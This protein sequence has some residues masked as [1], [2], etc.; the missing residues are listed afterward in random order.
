MLRSLKELESY[1]VSAINGEVGKVTDFL[2]D[3]QH[4]TARYLVTDT[5]GFWEVSN[6]VLISPISF[7]SVDWSTRLFQV[8]L[9]QE[10]VKKSPSVDLAK[11]V[12]RQYEREYSHYY[13]WPYYWGFAGS[14]AWG[15]GP[16]PLAL[17]DRSTKG[18][19]AR[20]QETN[21]DPHLRS[22]N[23]VIGY[24]VHGTDGEIGHIA[25]FIMDDETWTIRY[26]VIDTS[27]WWIGKKVLVAPHWAN[28]ISWSE[29]MVYMALTREAIKSSPEW[30]QTALVEREFEERLYSHYS[31][32]PYW[33][34][35]ELEDKAG[36][37]PEA[38][39]HLAL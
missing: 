34:R 19:T 23:A 25:D 28:K 8:A 39:R 3:D 33:L 18:E 1:K 32:P 17:A 35:R 14:W 16:Y 37:Q 27:N 31:R 2:F 13:G 11:P 30:T 24:H 10:K 15:M 38:E 22:V 7:R 29:K 6:Q 9:T 36:D 21:D 20:T 26:L 4:W 5:S 12:S